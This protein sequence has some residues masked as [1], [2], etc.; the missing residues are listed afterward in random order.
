MA[1]AAPPTC[2][3]NWATYWAVREALN[4]CPRSAM[5]TQDT[6]YDDAVPSEGRL[7]DLKKK[8]PPRMTDES[9]VYTAAL[10]VEVMVKETTVLGARPTNWMAAKQRGE[11]TRVSKK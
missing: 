7:A 5:D 2:L 8:A 6:G 4:V 11:Q 1:P 9:V 10:T 3:L